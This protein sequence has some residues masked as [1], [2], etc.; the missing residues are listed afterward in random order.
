M[1]KVFVLFILSG[2]IIGT[3]KAQSKLEVPKITQDKESPQI[4]LGK[5]KWKKTIAPPSVPTYEME[6]MRE[7]NPRETVKNPFPPGGL[8]IY[9]EY[10]ALIRNT[11]KKKIEG[12]SWEYIFYDSDSSQE[13]DRH[14]FFSFETIGNLKSAF[15]RGVSYAPP[16]KI[17]SMQGLEKDKRSPYIERVEVRC[18]LYGDNSFWVNEKVPSVECQMLNR[19][20]ARYRRKR[21]LF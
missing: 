21:K 4:S 19:N 17:V 5:L 2:L 20:R 13:L 14:R 11:S 10:Q 6:N 18:V 8:K 9:Y 1:P 16:S 3:V 15:V 7:N 12:I